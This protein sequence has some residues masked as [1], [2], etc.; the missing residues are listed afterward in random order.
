MVQLHPLDLIMLSYLGLVDPIELGLPSLIYKSMFHILGL[1]VV[2]HGYFG[3]LLIMV[4]HTFDGKRLGN[5]ECC[6]M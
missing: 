6:A 2:F 1:V 4:V 3:W 5:H